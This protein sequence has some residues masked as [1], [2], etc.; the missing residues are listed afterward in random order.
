MGGG[1]IRGHHPPSPDECGVK[2]AHGDPCILPR[3]HDPDFLW[4][5]R[6]HQ[7]AD[8]TNF[9]WAETQVTTTGQAIN[10][11]PYPYI[12]PYG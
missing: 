7:A 2:N 8:G 3:G 12:A 4:T 9:T 1:H 11:L 10:R 5:A 6:T